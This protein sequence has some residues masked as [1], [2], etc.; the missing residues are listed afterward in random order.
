[1]KTRFTI[2]IPMYNAQD[3]ILL[4]LKSIYKQDFKNYKILIIDDYSNDN[5]ILLVKNFIKENDITNITLIQNTENKGAGYSR[6]IALPLVNSD[7]ILFLDSDDEYYDSQAL[8]KLDKIISNTNPDLIY[9]DLITAGVKDYTLICD[10]LNTTREY[11]LGKWIYANI[12]TICWKTSFVLDNNIKCAEGIIYEDLLFNFKGIYF[13]KS[14][15]I[16]NLILILYKTRDNSVSTTVNFHQPYSKIKIIEE[17]YSL[18]SIMNTDELYLLKERIELEKK[19]LNKKIDNI[20]N[21]I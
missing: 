1:M 7:N 4:T 12:H 10:K 19:G 13:A 15:E 16:A 17:L 2:I 11:R 20:L 14:Y 6:N 9:C 5:S 3:S 8:S 21:T 18:K